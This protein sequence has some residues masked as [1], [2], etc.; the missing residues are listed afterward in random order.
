MIARRMIARLY[1]ALH[2]P[3]RK[4]TLT[5][6]TDTGNVSGRPPSMTDRFRYEP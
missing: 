1:D 2:D 4:D 6:A 3:A 5:I